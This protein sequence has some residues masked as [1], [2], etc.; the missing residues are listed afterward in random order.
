MKHALLF[1]ALLL[2]TVVA[3]ADAGKTA[4]IYYSGDQTVGIAGDSTDCFVEAIF[5]QSGSSVVVRAILAD[6]HSAELVGIGTTK[7]K[8]S[9]AKQAHYFKSNH[10]DSP[11][12]ELQLTAVTKKS[13][14]ELAL[15]VVDGG[16]FDSLTC[17]NLT[18]AQDSVVS[19]MFE[20]FEDY[21]DESDDHD[22]DDHDHDHHH[23]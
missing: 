12:Q 8:Y 5:S 19:E 7:A 23:H 3:S 1:C 17:K 6:A 4:A 2:S 18:P 15:V 10:N 9:S 14:Q 20:H 16:H 11:V 21:T 22:H 13:P